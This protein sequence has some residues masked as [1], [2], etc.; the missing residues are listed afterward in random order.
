L[1]PQQYFGRIMETQD[2]EFIRVL[3][4][5]I[6]VL[7]AQGVITLDMLPSRA[8]AKFQQRRSMRDMALAN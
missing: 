2:Q 3:E 8:A 4:D 1:V 6:E 5:L 7:V